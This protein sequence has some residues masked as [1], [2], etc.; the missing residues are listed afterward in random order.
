M[1]WF[2]WIYGIGIL[3]WIY[4]FF[5]VLTNDFED[6]NNKIVWILLLIFLP[7]AA[8]L[9]PFIGRRQLKDKG[10][11]L[12]NI[13]KDYDTTPK[14]INKTKHKEKSKIIAI[15]LNIL[16]PG[17]GY[18]YV[19]NIKKTLFFTML[20]PLFIYI[21]LFIATFYSNIYTVILNYSI[22]I[23][24]YIYMVYDILKI[25][26]QKKAKYIKLN[27]WYFII[28]FYVLY[29]IYIILL[30]NYAPVRLFVQTAASMKST[31]I[32]GDRVIAVKD[33]L[34]HRGDVIVFKYPKNTSIY[35]VKRCIA[36][37]GDE[38]LFQEK[39]LYI[40]FRE[41]DKWIKKHYPTTRIYKIVGKLWVLNPYM[42]KHP[43]IQYD[44]NVNFFREILLYMSAGQFAMHPMM[45][46]SLPK[47]S[48][49]LPLNAFYYKVSDGRYF[50]MGDNR[51]HSSDSRFW[52]AVPQKLIFGKAK[53]IFIN[54][55]NLSRC[56]LS[57]E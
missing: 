3:F 28:L 15:I 20:F 25:F 12:K 54:F 44:R 9:Y 49:D 16:S 34:V 31:I 37:G 48:N 24:V 38:I 52:G 30:R 27:K 21:Q 1:S 50:M 18:L 40:H 11:N 7:V 51:D 57:I 17:I 19:G 46:S 13:N 41:G 47:Y 22:I 29:I 32:K 5:S 42:L 23:L 2:L 33:N 53:T 43:G 35:Y 6:S 55:N 56:G 26:S 14:E 45:I 4:S 8:V 39:K 10:K 36:V